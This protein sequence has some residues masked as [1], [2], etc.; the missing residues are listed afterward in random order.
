LGF[1]GHISPSDVTYHPNPQKDRPWAEPR[2]LAIKREYRPRGSS[3]AL[4]REKNRVQEKSKKKGYISPIWGEAPIEANYIKK[5]VVDDLLDIIA[6]ARFQDEILGVTIL[7]VVKS[8]FLSIFE[9]ALQQ[10]SA[11]V[12]PD[13]SWAVPVSE[14]LPKQLS[15]KKLHFIRINWTTPSGKF[16]LS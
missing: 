3:W 5:Y 2:H 16:L 9:W 15:R 7:Q 8:I 4:E 1:W 11:T 10:C 6:C 13:I 14:R 12:L